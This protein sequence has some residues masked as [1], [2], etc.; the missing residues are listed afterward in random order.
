MLFR[1]LADLLLLLH[2]GFVLFVAAGGLLLLR[3]PRVAYVHLPV[4]L[5]GALIEF[6]GGI[7]PLTP[8]EQY[9]RRRGGEAGYT[10]G[11][12][13]HYLTAAIYPSGL[14]RGIQIVLGVIVVLVNVGFYWIWWRRRSRFERT[15]E[16][17]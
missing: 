12:I 15:N 2:M 16:K 6:I 13:E 10:G 8:L 14:T 9:L 17:R 1:A 7:C 4:A 5:W 11:F 3:W